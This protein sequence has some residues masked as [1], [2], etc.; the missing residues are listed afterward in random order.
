VKRRS[1]PGA[2]IDPATDPAAIQ[3]SLSLAE[4]GGPPYGDDEERARADWFGGYRAWMIRQTLA[5]DANGGGLAAIAFWETDP[6][7]LSWNEAAQA[8]YEA[9]D[10]EDQLAYGRAAARYH[11]LAVTVRARLDAGD[12]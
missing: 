1:A 8:M 10:G 5:I 2:T 12:L 4:G 9:R 3:K 7:L 11:R 6:V